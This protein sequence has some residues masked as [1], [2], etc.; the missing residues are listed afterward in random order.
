MRHPRDASLTF[1][2]LFATANEA[3]PPFVPLTREAIE[4]QI[5]SV[6]TLPMC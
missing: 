2:D 5:G 3:P 1:R 6:T 4:A